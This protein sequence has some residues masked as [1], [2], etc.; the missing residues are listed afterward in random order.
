[1]GTDRLGVLS[2]QKDRPPARK[3]KGVWKPYY[4]S[5]VFRFSQ[6]CHSVLESLLQDILF[7]L[8]FTGHPVS[9]GYGIVLDKEENLCP[10]KNL[11]AS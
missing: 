2:A 9:A 10:T 4:T 6:D 8:D 3:E 11:Q 7:L 1:M 5:D